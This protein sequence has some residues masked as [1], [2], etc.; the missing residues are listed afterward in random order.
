MHKMQHDAL[1]GGVS[2]YVISNVSE[3]PYPAP[4][5]LS[6]T[7]WRT[8]SITLLLEQVNM[9]YIMHKFEFIIV[10]I[11]S[12]LNNIDLIKLGHNHMDESKQQYCI[13]E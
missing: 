13:E 11:C 8:F 1:L 5:D 6:S 3:T 7:R 4:F 2:H 12:H 9:G 10:Q